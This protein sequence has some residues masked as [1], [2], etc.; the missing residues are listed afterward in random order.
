M[1]KKKV[2]KLNI[3]K[4]VITLVAVYVVCHL[5]Y[6]ATSIVDLKM[7]QGQLSQELDAAYTEQS[8]LQAELDYMNSEDAVEKIAREKLG[9]VKDGEILIRHIDTSQTQ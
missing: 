8:E 6:G 5:I 9:L 3:R 1:A 2:K 7:Q 4:T